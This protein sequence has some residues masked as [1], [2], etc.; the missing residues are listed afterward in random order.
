M[1]FLKGF[2]SLF[3]W[4]SPRTLDDSM[5]ELYDKMNWGEYKNPLKYPYPST[6]NP[7]SVSYSYN[8][9][10][11]ITRASELA[12]P[13][14][15]TITTSQQFLDEMRKLV[16]SGDFVPYAYYNEEMDAIEAYFK[17]KSCYTQTLNENIELHI[18]SDNEEVVGINI[19]NIKKLIKNK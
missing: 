11:D 14:T 13:H 19:L 17:N 15:M 7:C 8:T 16:P 18:A 2:F 12:N 4:M 6:D 9:A 1:S 5:Q 10:A 3:D